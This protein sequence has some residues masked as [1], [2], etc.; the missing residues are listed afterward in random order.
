M[1]LNFSLHLN[2]LIILR[3]AQWEISTFFL[4]EVDAH[5]KLL[6]PCR[7]LYFPIA[8]LKIKVILEKSR[9]KQDIKR[10]SDER[11]EMLLKC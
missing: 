10:A 7:C 4:L 5:N 1:K 9:L 8:H 2:L 3:Q 11:G 6:V